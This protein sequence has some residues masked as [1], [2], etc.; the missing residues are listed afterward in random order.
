[1]IDENNLFSKK[2]SWVHDP[3]ASVA[4]LLVPKICDEV[5][6]GPLRRILN[7]QNVDIEIFL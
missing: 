6:F 2:K 5:F 3:P 1:M 7:H 4:L